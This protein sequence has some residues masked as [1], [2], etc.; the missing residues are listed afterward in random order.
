MY[1]QIKGTAMGPKNTCAYADVAINAIDM[2]VNERDW[3]PE[4]RLIFWGRYW[5]DIY[6]PWT[7]G[8]EKLESFH[9]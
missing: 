6:I 8:L 4:Y 9:V 3:D 2:K 5:D 1:R 7:H